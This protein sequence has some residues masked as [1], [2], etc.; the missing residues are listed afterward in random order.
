MDTRPIGVYDSGVGGLTGLSA[1]MRMLPGEDFVYFS[2]SGRMPYGPRPLPQLRR[3]AMQDM[4]YLAS[5]G[6]KA[7]LAACGTISSAAKAELT[8]YPIP[9]F[10]V[11]TPALDTMA[12]VPGDGPLAIIATA[13]SISS[14]EFTDALWKKCGMRREIVGMPCPEFAPLIE[15]GHTR[16]DDPLVRECVAHALASVRDRSFDAILLGCT[17]YGFIEEAIRDY[18]GEDVNLLS[19]ADCGAAALRDYLVQNDLIGGERRERR[20]FVSGDTRAFET[21]AEPYLQIGP[22]H[23][24]QAPIMII[25]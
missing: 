18:L 2:D 17:H 9:A 24:E 14:G 13:A 23:A 19:A 3:I 20:F 22:V 21:F 8:A 16:R 10:G 4:D 6:V 7:I 11:L 15:S 1:L 25:A 12:Q 5:F